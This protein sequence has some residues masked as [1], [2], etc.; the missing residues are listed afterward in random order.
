MAQKKNIIKIENAKNSFLYAISASKDEFSFCNSINQEF[1]ISLMIQ[2]PL[3]YELSSG[4][5]ILHSFYSTVDE[6]R[7]IQFD[8]ISNKTEKGI[9]V[10]AMD[11]IN[12]FIRISN[13][14]SEAKVVDVKKKISQLESVIYVQKVDIEKCTPKQRMQL[15]HLFV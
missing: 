4:A 12:F 11:S 7:K 14:Y 13:L 3:E 1:N 9:L 6:I 5:S 2:Q 8:V 15:T 10:D